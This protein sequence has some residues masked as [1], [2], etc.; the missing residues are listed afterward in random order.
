MLVLRG[1]HHAI[2]Q[3]LKAQPPARVGER[4]VVGLQG[5]AAELGGAGGMEQGEVGETQQCWGKEEQRDGLLQGSCFS[6]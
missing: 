3:V 4:G 1:I 6:S 5:R 2:S